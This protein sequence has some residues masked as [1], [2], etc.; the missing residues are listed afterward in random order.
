MKIE[1]P[2]VHE[3]R[4][5]DPHRC[6]FADAMSEYLWD[7]SLADDETGSCDWHYHVSRFG[8]RLLFCDDR[9]FVWVEKCAD[10][11]EANERF[12]AIDQSYCDYEFGER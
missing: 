7:V 12:A 8:K 3:I 9:G 5:T 2:E 10:E 1:W 4:W 6:K 11:M